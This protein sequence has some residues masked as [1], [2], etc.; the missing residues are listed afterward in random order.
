[1]H[2]TRVSKKIGENKENERLLYS[3]TTRVNNGAAFWA[4]LK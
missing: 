2:S 1:M 4:L 3:T